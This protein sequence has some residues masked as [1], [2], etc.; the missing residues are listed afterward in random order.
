MS[1]LVIFNFLV[2]FFIFNFTIS[3]L[4][5]LEDLARYNIVIEIIIIPP[6]IGE[7]KITTPKNK[8]IHK[9]RFKK[10]NFI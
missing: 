1:L 5:N 9:N 3:F 10:N 8:N 6:G 2:I 7:I 4:A